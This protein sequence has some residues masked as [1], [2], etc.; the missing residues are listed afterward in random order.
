[1][2]FLHKE[3]KYAHIVPYMKWQQR[4][5]YV[6]HD[7]CNN[8]GNDDDADDAYDND[9]GNDY[10]DSHFLDCVQTKSHCVFEIL[11]ALQ[12]SFL[13]ESPQTPQT[14]ITVITIVGAYSCVKNFQSKEMAAKSFTIC[15]SERQQQI[16]NKKRRD[17]INR[18]R[19]VNRADK[20]R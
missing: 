11:S 7:K 4:T 17:F 20:Q 6:L 1:M 18:Y 8:D 5:E 14:P 16:A 13:S 9:H 3:A 19:T 15:E 10:V 2:F 12:K